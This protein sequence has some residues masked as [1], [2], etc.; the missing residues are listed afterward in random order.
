M[1]YKK[2][3]ARKRAVTSPFIFYPPIIVSFYAAA[4]NFQVIVYRNQ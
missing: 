3:T 4:L 1:L 2:E